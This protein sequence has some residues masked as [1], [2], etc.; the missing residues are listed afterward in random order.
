MEC[1]FDHTPYKR[2]LDNYSGHEHLTTSKQPREY[3]EDNFKMKFGR[4]RR[5]L[6]KYSTMKTWG[7]VRPEPMGLCT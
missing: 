5:R 4:T 1:E 3:L 6:Q 2:R 7:L